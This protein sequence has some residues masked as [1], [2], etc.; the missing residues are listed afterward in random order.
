MALAPAASPAIVT[1]SVPVASPPRTLPVDSRAVV[2]LASAIVGAAFIVRLPGVVEPIGPDQGVYATIAWGLQRGLSLYRDLWEQKPPAIYLTY[3]LGFWLFGARLSSIFWLDYLAAALTTVVLFDVGRRLAGLRS[4][5]LTAAAFALAT[6]PAARHGLGGF[7]ERSVTETFIV[8]LVAMAAWSSVMATM[9]VT[10][11]WAFAA[12]VFIGTAAVFKQTALIYWPAFALWTWVVAGPAAMRR[13][14]V[15]CGLGALVCPSLALVW[16]WAHGLLQD[17]W[18]ALVQ[19]NMA[20]LALEV[21]GQA[22]TLN[23][24]AHEVWRRMKT[25][26]VW[27]FGSLSATIAATAVYVRW[28]RAETLSRVAVLGIVWYAAALIAIVANGPRMFSTYFMPSLAPLSVLSAWLL[29]QTFGLRRSRRLAASV[30]LVG[31]AAFMLVRSGSVN[32]AI[33]MTSWDARHRFG[34]MDRQEYLQ[35]FRSR[36]AQ[37]FSAA[38]NEWLADYIRAHTNPD[39]RIFVFG[40]SAGTY[41]LSGRLPASKFLWAY[42]A[43]SNMIDRPEFRVETLASDLGRIAPRY[44]VLQRHNGDSFSGWRATDAF[45]APPM[46]ALLRAYHEETEIGDFLLYR[47]NDVGP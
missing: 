14:T 10:A 12:G 32:R 27:G 34:K 19:Y 46:T 1:M 13:F 9:R 35:K 30:A 15:S 39:D 17:A 31:F 28:R 11:R 4:G 29:D 16:L 2:W 43:V 44:I 20:Y 42:P 5:A 7:L 41:F 26:E 38:D 40:M 33:G 37:A 21:P 6:L 23:R 25:D 24:F 3:R 8:P 18:V 45:A 47:R 36:W 22:G